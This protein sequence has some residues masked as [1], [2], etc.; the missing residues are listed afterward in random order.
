MPD[1]VVVIKVKASDAGAKPEMDALK[2]ELDELG[3]KVAEAR[4]DVDDKEGA[5]K[6]KNLNAQ[7]IALGQRVANPKITL[8]GAARVE[9]QLAAVDAALGKIGQGTPEKVAANLA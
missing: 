9:A 4:V 8:A 1:N 3:R 7:L 6:L 2:A 5:A